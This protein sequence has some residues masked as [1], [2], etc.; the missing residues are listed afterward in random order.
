[1]ADVT[2]GSNIDIVAA[3]VQQ[4]REWLALKCAVETRGAQRI[5]R[6]AAIGH[7]EASQVISLPQGGQKREERVRDVKLVGQDK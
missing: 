1:M 4:S 7:T 6:Y 3:V 2:A 5:A